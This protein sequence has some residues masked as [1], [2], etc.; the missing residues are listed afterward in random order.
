[1]PRPPEALRLDRMSTPL[2]EALLVTDT[3]GAMRALDWTTHETRLLTLLRRQNPP[4]DLVSGAAPA[5]M[6][7]ALAAYFEGD[8]TALDGVTWRTGGTDFQ[9]AVWAALCSIPVGE[10][11]TYKGLAER[12]DRPK[13]IRAVGLANGANPVS[14]VVPCHRVIGADGTLTGYG[15]GL[16][17]KQWLLIHEGAAFVDP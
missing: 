14:I 13:A 16:D 9:R 5:A 3:D 10:T 6:R 4:T 11:L 1:M 2:G 15:G 12:I 17:R 8:L 7:A